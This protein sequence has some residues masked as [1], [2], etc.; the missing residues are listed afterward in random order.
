MTINGRL[1]QSTWTLLGIGFSIQRCWRHSGMKVAWHRVQD[2]EVKRYEVVTF[3]CYFCSLWNSIPWLGCCFQSITVQCEKRHSQ[4][5]RRSRWRDLHFAGR[6]V[7]NHQAPPQ[8][9][10]D[11]VVVFSILSR[12]LN[13]FKTEDHPYWA[14]WLW[15]QKFLIH[16]LVARRWQLTRF[17]P[18]L[19]APW[20]HLLTAGEV[21]E[22]WGVVPGGVGVIG[23]QVETPRVAF[24]RGERCSAEKNKLNFSALKARDKL[25]FSIFQSGCTCFEFVLIDSKNVWYIFTTFLETLRKQKQQ[26]GFSRSHW[27][28][29][30][31]PF[32]AFSM[33]F[34]DQ[35]NWIS[36]ILIHVHPFSNSWLS[37]IFK[38]ARYGK[39][40]REKNGLTKGVQAHCTLLSQ[41]AD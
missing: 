40:L 25:Y 11:E 28:L 17:R 4:L 7:D 3:H 5:P 23:G 27:P 38:A 8:F 22:T 15:L 19:L 16:L 13:T 18:T 29:V 35:K 34:F 21:V 36:S 1:Q 37:D 10:G 31:Q 14:Y 41:W 30:N 24:K 20:I 2:V 32:D 12:P 9:S 26:Y 6:S 39:T 33:V